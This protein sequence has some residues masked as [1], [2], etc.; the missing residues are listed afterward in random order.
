[1]SGDYILKRSGDRYMFN[2]RAGNY[3]VILVSQRYATKAGAQNG[4]ES[5]RK[6]AEIDGR[7]K[8]LKAKDGSDYFNLTAGNGEIVGTSEMYESVAAMNKGIE[9]VKANGPTAIVKDQTL[10]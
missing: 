10:D 6:N 9:S 3:Q 5:V 1:M 4:I 7:Y 8:R 2:L